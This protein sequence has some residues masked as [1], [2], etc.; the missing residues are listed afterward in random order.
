MARCPHCNKAIDVSLIKALAAEDIDRMLSAIDDTSLEGDQAKFISELR[1]R[2]ERYGD[3]TR[4]TQPQRQWLSD[5]A[6]RYPV[7]SLDRKVEGK[8]EF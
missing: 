4:V 7:I 5:L 6:K 1:G 2:L 3:R 8:E